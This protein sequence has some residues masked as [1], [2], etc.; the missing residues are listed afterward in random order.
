MTLLSVKRMRRCGAVRTFAWIVALVLLLSPTARGEAAIEP[1]DREGHDRTR[2]PLRG[3][4]QLVSCESCHLRSSQ[5]GQGRTWKGAPL[6]CHGC[7]GDRRNH[8]GALGKQCELCHDDS[9]WK[10]IKHQA[11]QH[12]MK[13]VGKHDLKCASCH[14]QGAHLT[15]SVT[16]AN[17]HAL[18]HGGTSSP[19]ETC[20]NVDDWKTVAFTKHTYDPEQLPGKHR[21]LAC[22]ACHPA[23]QF[24]HTSVRCETCHVK[25]QPHEDLGA[26]RRCHSPLTWKKVA[27]D[28]QTSAQATIF[29][30][31]SKFEHTAHARLVTA[32][33]QK[34]TCN[35]CHV[36]L[37][38]RKRP[39]ME[40][41]EGCHDGKGAFDARGTQCARCHEAPR[42]TTLTAQPRSPKAFQHATHER[43]HNVNID[44]CASCHGS[45][46]TWEKVQAGRDQHRPCQGCHAAEFR[47]A[48]PICLGCHERND[49]FRPNPLRQHT[50]TA[51]EFRSPDLADIPHAPH[52]AEGVACA[53]CHAA[54]SGMAVRNPTL[55]HAL[56][57]QCHDKKGAKLTLDRCSACHVAASQRRRS[58]KRQ[59][60]TREFFKHDDA[61][62][63]Q[64]CGSCHQPDG[65]ATLTPPTM[66]GCASCHDG[67]K[68]FP[69]I[70]KDC[71]RCHGTRLD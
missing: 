51:S 61:H 20:H 10:S 67:H 3:R 19:C 58:I 47:K 52:I 16:C 66:Q 27:P 18:P 4:H 68:A 7:H 5:S 35:P 40:S 25:D 24:K 39:T 60:S 22:L 32:R 36:G 48:G 34:P 38:F 2:F 43:L 53:A 8:K 33:G 11:D 23:F 69:T 30:V 44:D 45:G 9:G 54:Q 12:H 6:D 26:C 14:P 55:G 15:R 49:P 57:G 50:A 28:Q 41:C 42:G 46:T 29:R 62:R 56:C 64:P 63:A 70:G 17:C 37:D 65:A 13:L 21:T 1:I 31:K 71:A 59:W